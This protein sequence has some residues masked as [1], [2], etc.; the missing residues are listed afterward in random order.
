MVR[1]D[2]P[3]PDADELERLGV[4]DPRAPDAADHLE[5]IR[6]VLALGATIEDV[7]AANLREL[8]LD[9]T[10]RPR[11][12]LTLG[13]AAAAA[14]LEWPTAERLMTAVGISADPAGRIT[15]DEAAAVGLFAGRTTTCSANRPRC[16]S[17]G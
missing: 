6:Y 9:L 12:P 8:A 1:E 14:G 10:L 17:P 13:E 3:T 4:Y 11:G 2:P 5:L 7:T 15:N 16:S